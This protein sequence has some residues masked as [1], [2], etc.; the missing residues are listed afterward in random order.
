MAQVPGGIVGDSTAIIEMDPSTTAD[1]VTVH[2]IVGSFFAT[3][4]PIWNVHT[5][6]QTIQVTG[7]TLTVPKALFLGFGTGG[8][9]V[10]FEITGSSV[11]GQDGEAFTGI[12]SLFGTVESGFP[13]VFNFSRL[14]D[15]NA[16]PPAGPGLGRDAD[17]DSVD[18]ANGLGPRR[19]GCPR[20]VFSTSEGRREALAMD[21][22]NPYSI[23][24]NDAAQAAIEAG[25]FEM[26]EKCIDVHAAFLPD[27]F[28]DMVGYGRGPDGTNLYPVTAGGTLK[29]AGR[30]YIG[31]NNEEYFIADEEMVIELAENVATGFVSSVARGDMA[32]GRPDSFVMND[33]LVIFNQDPRFGADVLGVGESEI[34]RKVFFD[35]MES[36]LANGTPVLID[37][38]GHTVGEHVLFAQE[39]LTE[40]ID[41]I[42]GAQ[43]TADRFR[44]RTRNGASEARWRGTAS[45]V[46]NLSL[47]AGAVGTTWT[48]HAMFVD[49][50]GNVL[51]V[52]PGQTEFNVPF[53]LN[54]LPNDPSAA[55][56]DYDFRERG[57]NLTLAVMARMEL[58]DGNGQVVAQNDFPI[59]P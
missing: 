23:Y 49:A 36:A 5:M 45:P 46:E 24:R 43:V 1:D 8:T 53:Q 9:E 26:T 29:S 2:A 22:A 52:L 37:L 15:G 55:I 42:A 12:N 33:L 58:R 27:G 28:K 4:G 54:P 41:P 44:I 17:S 34:R 59:S 50:A 3:E 31:P 18:A 47:N 30:R 11:L 16:C 6:T 35:E 21:P 48:L 14:E 32:T 40:F 38:I 39:V 13:G 51:T 57:L 25:F 56:A 10:S 19:L 7:K 20:S